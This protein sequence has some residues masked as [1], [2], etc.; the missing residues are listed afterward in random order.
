MTR[1]MFNLL[2]RSIVRAVILIA[3][4]FVSGA[5]GQKEDSS[6]RNND[7]EKSAP[8]VIKTQAQFNDII[9]TSGSNLIMV[10][11]YAD[12]CKPCKILSPILEDIAE[13]NFAKV[14]VYKLNVDK[15]RALAS[16][17]RISGVPV[18]IF[19]KNKKQIYK[20]YGL[21]PKNRYI[22]AIEKLSQ[23]K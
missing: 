14:T 5:Y 13:K 18:V 16:R 22:E 3:C 20:M 8:I 6:T 21:Q 15:H 23:K 19:F 12:W 17:F 4:I 11:F 7:P 9:G 2:P 10:D 1:T